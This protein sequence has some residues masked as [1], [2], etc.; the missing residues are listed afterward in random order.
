MNQ[1]AF[2][3]V[4]LP[5]SRYP[6]FGPSKNPSSFPTPFHSFGPSRP[7]P[8]VINPPAL[9]SFRNYGRHIIHHFVPRSFHHVIRRRTLL[10]ARHH[11]RRPRTTSG[12]RQY[13]AASAWPQRRR[14][15]QQQPPAS[16]VIFSVVER[17]VVRNTLR[18]SASV[19]RG[20]LVSN[21]H[22]DH[23]D[24]VAVLSR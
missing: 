24:L 12:F 3:V 16:I 22:A 23:R 8:L 13:E 10:A 2:V 1:V 6:S 18:S 9:P 21:V 11:G 14:R 4:P 15:R 20:G 19:L 5:N 7:P 17:C